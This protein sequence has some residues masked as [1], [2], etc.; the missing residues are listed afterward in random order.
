MESFPAKQ[1][2]PEVVLVLGVVFRGSEEPS[3]AQH[4]HVGALGASLSALHCFRGTYSQL[5]AAEADGSPAPMR[6]TELSMRHDDRSFFHGKCLCLPGTP[7][8]EEQLRP[9]LVRKIF[10]FWIL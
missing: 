3:T 9:C 7:G 6:Q 10:R 5:G 4:A 1:M 2:A 8:L